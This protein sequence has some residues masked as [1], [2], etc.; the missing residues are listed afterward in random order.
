MFG[1]QS[2]SYLIEN[3]ETTLVTSPLATFY[4]DR[5]VEKEVLVVRCLCAVVRCLSAV[6]QLGG[7]QL[8]LSSIG[9]AQYLDG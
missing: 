9:P 3:N 1:S 5:P 4:N 8:K 6:G 7:K 2:S